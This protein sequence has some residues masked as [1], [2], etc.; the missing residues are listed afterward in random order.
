MAVRAR[1]HASGLDQAN[2]RLLVERGTRAVAGGHVWRS[3]QRLTLPSP[4]RLDEAQVLDL[5]HLLAKHHP[6]THRRDQ[7]GELATLR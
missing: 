1:I 3:D 5:L 7:P 2:A 4:T 6:Q